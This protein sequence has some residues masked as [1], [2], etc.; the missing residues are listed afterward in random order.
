MFDQ[1]W[2]KETQQGLTV[3]LR[4]TDMEIGIQPFP[5]S[6]KLSQPALEEGEVLSARLNALARISDPEFREPIQTGKEL[7]FTR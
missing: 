5:V 7:V 2:S 1:D 4:V 3:A 6:I